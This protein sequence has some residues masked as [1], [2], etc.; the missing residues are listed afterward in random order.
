MNHRVLHN[1]KPT[2]LGV[3]LDRTLTFN[4]HVKTVRG[5]MKA[6]NNLL[7]AISGTTSGCAASDL[8]S[9]Y[10]TFSGPEPTTPLAP[11]CP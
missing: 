10:M 9:T 6:R 11:G 5:R 7:R 2:F 3:T 1:P 8:R 4:E